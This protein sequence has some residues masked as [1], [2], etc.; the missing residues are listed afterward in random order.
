MFC[1]ARN[2][3]PQAFAFHPIVPVRIQSPPVWTFGS[4]RFHFSINLFF[5]C[6][7]YNFILCVCVS[8]LPSVSPSIGFNWFRVN[9][10]IYVNVSPSYLKNIL[11]SVFALSFLPLAFSISFTTTADIRLWLLLLERS[12]DHGFTP[13]I[14]AIVSPA[15]TWQSRLSKPK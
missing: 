4:I 8:H 2:S 7:K 9:D 1:V 14:G 5:F 12:L 15:Q 10:N 3:T 13:T 6:L 11:S